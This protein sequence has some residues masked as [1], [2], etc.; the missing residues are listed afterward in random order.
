MSIELS[1]HF[2]DNW[3]ERVGTVPTVETVASVLRKCIVVQKGRVVYNR[4]GRRT[5]ILAIFWSH[6]LGVILTADHIRRRMVSVMTPDACRWR[7]NL[8]VL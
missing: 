2:I 6:E 1:Q 5:N 4:C 3:M 7:A 8:Y